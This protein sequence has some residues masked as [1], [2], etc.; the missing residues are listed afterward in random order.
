GVLW[1]VVIVVVCFVPV[2]RFSVLV[3]EEGN[4]GLVFAREYINYFLFCF[5]FEVDRSMWFCLVG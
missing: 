1:V 4:L 2:V 3:L 5:F